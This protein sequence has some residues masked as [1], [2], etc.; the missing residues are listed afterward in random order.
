MTIRTPL[1]DRLD[2]L[3]IRHKTINHPAVFTV[4]ESQDVK[5][6][7]PGGHSKNLFLKDKAGTLTLVTAYAHTQIDLKALGKHLNSKQRLSFGKPD[8]MEEVLGVSPGSV[9]PFALL[10]DTQRQ[11]TNVVLDA[12]LFDHD[13]VW[14]H[15]LENTA[16]TAIS[17]SDLEK[18]VRAC[19]YEPEVLPLAS[20]GQENRD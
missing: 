3:A 12:A 5:R 11:V 15:P 14:F 20:L 16:S 6:S 10:N 17:P 4:E 2:E 8:L 9:T 13:P 19:G 7:M 18:F 1:F